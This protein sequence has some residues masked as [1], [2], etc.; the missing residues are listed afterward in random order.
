MGK[1]LTWDQALQFPHVQLV[2]DELADIHFLTGEKSAFMQNLG[3]VRPT[4]ETD[5]LSTA[6]QVVRN[7]DYLFPAPPLFMEQDEISQDLIA[8]PMPEG[9]E[10]TLKY[11]LVTHPRIEHSMVHQ[12][13]YGE[14]IEVIEHFRGKYNLPP[15]AEL[16]ARM[17]L[18]Y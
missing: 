9:E 15:L 3:K 8:L 5:Q 17:N 2:I 16:R 7:S 18:D 11:L 14:I 4:L 6:I 10:V 12:F 1:A 13:L